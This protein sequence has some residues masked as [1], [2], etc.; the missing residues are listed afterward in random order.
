MT[1]SR[2]LLAVAA[3]L[4][5]ATALFVVLGAV[6]NLVLLA[7]AVPFGIA[8]YFLW[9]HATGRLQA[10]VHRRFDGAEAG[11]R[12]RR[13]ARSGQRATVGPDEPTSWT[14]EDGASRSM[15]R[16][17]AFATLDLAPG[18]DQRAIRQA[19]RDRVKAVHPDA[20]GGDEDE[21]RRVR[22]AYDRLRGPRRGKG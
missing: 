3:V 17:E 4:A 14:T 13:A 18:A 16:A 5:G 6:F 1:R 22:A 21:F 2:L 10:R 7:A 9:S 8:A 11:A 15:D 12:R 20:D 19:Y